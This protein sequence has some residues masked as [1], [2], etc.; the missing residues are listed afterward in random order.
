MYRSAVEVV[1]RR[2]F[3]LLEQAARQ[4]AE[5]LPDEIARLPVRLRRRLA[6][7]ELQMLPESLAP[8]AMEHAE[9]ALE[10]H[11]RLVARARK[12][13]AKHRALEQ[14]ER[15]ERA[16][17]WKTRAWWLLPVGVVLGPTCVTLGALPASRAH[18][19]PSCVDPVDAP[20]ARVEG[21][22]AGLLRGPP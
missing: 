5:L 20:K 13:S 16:L 22:D 1:R 6:A 11:R 19:A 3:A 10:T 12:A 17:R 2:Y 8:A 9:R 18:P 4:R 14:H 21:G 15:R 7:A